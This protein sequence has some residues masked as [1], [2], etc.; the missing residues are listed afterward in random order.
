[1]RA[2]NFI[3][4]M[5]SVVLF[6]CQQTSKNQS[7]TFREI[8]SREMSSCHDLVNFFLT[9]GAKILESKVDPEA[10]ELYR[11]IFH[12]IFLLPDEKEILMAFN[13]KF[14]NDDQ[15][16]WRLKSFLLYS[17]T[18][19][20]EKKAEFLPEVAKVFDNERYSLDE[21]KEF[22]KF[23]R[24]NE[25]NV[26]RRKSYQDREFRRLRRNHIP[27]EEAIVTA[28]RYAYDRQMPYER[29]YYACRNQVKTVDNPKSEAKMLTY[30]ITVGG[31]LSAASTYTFVNW[32]KEKDKKWWT[33]IGNTI[34]WSLIINFGAGKILSNPAWG[35]V[36]KLLAGIAAQYG[37]DA[38]VST[39]YWYFSSETDEEKLAKLQEIQNSE[40]FQEIKT[41]MFRLMEEQGMMEKYQQEMKNLVVKVRGDGV[42]GPMSTE[43]LTEEE[44]S[45]LSM[46]EMDHEST[47]LLFIE[48]LS[49]YEYEQK[50]VVFGGTGNPYHDRYVFHRALDFIYQPA[51]LVA[52]MVMYKQI[53]LNPNPKMGMLQAVG[54]FMATKLALDTAYFFNR[55]CLLEGGCDWRETTDELVGEEAKE[56]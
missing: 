26:R 49:A 33:D 56:P 41:E 36:K 44:I 16:A 12:D 23:R 19:F 3:I 50:G 34:V 27:A 8:S 55:D 51:F 37:F 31:V 29:L 25:R 11:D 14:P 24:H 20:P 15:I 35:P 43:P 17:R 40:D 47:R 48:A 39:S 38:V 28:R 5:M 13:F 54:T 10:R 21:G 53:C 1:M 18:M 46:D 32:D 4:F 2:K 22:A 52:S 9:P 42:S 30:A 45:Q 6:S 7:Q